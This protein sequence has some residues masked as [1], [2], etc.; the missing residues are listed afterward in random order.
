MKQL[1]KVIRAGEI[2]EIKRNLKEK[3]Y[4]KQEQD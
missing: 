4:N 2:D 1:N 3:I